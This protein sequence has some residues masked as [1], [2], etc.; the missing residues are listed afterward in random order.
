M[1]TAWIIIGVAALTGCS[2]SNSNNQQA[3]SEDP[4]NYEVQ[5]TSSSQAPR[6]G[7]SDSVTPSRS[8]PTP[9][10]VPQSSSADSKGPLFPEFLRLPDSLQ[11]ALTARKPCADAIEIDPTAG[12]KVTADQV[13]AMLRE[14]KNMI[15]RVVSTAK[16]LEGSI[17]PEPE[18]STAQLGANAQLDSPQSRLLVSARDLLLADAIRCWETGDADGCG[19]RLDASLRIARFMLSQSDQ[20]TQF[21]GE[22]ALIPTIYE[23]SARIRRGLL[24][25]LSSSI[26]SDLRHSISAI[27]TAHLPH[28]SKD[29]NFDNAVKQCKAA[30]GNG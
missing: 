28:P 29:V 23:L 21:R 10:R 27:D 12:S 13:R 17:P 5:T 6:P 25:R 7:Q 3:Q 11:Q 2:D 30:L 9:T 18:Y 20:R 4:L 14:N 19:A 24:G 15:E 8:S 16:W 22:L 26:R 1:R